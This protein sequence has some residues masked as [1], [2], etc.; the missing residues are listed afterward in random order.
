MVEAALRDQEVDGESL[1]LLTQVT[2]KN[3]VTVEAELRDQEINGEWRV[4]TTPHSGN[5]KDQVMVEGAL[6]DQEID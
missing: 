4:A 2:T 5:P 1:L 6:K 3:Q